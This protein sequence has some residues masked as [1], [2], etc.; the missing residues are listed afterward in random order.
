MGTILASNPNVTLRLTHVQDSLG[1]VLKVDGRLDEE[2][3]S[4]LKRACEDFEGPLRLDLRDLIEADESAVIELRGLRASGA[5][6]IRIRPFL[7]LLID[8]GN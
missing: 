3:L 4:E 6:L 5:E 7:Q 2:V 8:E 1:L